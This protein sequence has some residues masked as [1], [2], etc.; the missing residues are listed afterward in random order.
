VIGSSGGQGA[1]CNTVH[2]APSGVLDMRPMPGQT[3]VMQRRF[4]RHE[5][6]ALGM[7]HLCPPDGDADAQGMVCCD[8]DHVTGE[9]APPKRDMRQGPITLPSAPHDRLRVGLTRTNSTGLLRGCHA[10]GTIPPVHGRDLVT[11]PRGQIG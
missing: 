8:R 9:T 11:V 2:D 6:R 7:R 10:P 5:R 1:P 3:G 4:H